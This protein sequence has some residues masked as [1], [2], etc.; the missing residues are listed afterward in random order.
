[1]Y[2][3]KFIGPLLA[4]LLPLLTACNEAPEGSPTTQSVGDAE[5]LTVYK[6]PS[7]GCCNK[8]V[9]HLETEGFKTAAEHAADLDAL[10]DG[11][12][13]S[14]NLRSCH[15]AVSSQGYVF[16]G[17][18]PARYIRQFLTSPPADAIGLSVP[19]MPLGSPG[20]EV[21]DKFMPYQVLLIKNDGSTEVFASV[22]RA[23]QQYQRGNKREQQP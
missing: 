17:H 6:S 2:R 15:T 1:M 23:V 16:E 3:S 9:E 12:G 10:K 7:C 21:D 8:W 5:M 13:I 14:T 11:Y 22:E 18:I 19:G 20:M 4:L